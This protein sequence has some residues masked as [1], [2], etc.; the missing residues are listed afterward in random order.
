MPARDR[1]HNTVIRALA[2]AGWAVTAEQ[3]AIIVAARRLWIDFQAVN[4]AGSRV[5]LVEVKGFEYMP[6]PVDYLGEVVGKY[7]LY[8]AALEYIQVDDP[9]CL[10]VPT[11]AYEG[12]LSEDIGQQV[13]MRAGI[14]LLI[15][16]PAKEE[17]VQWLP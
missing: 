8:R 11:A 13:I 17:V 5:I 3:V 2:R 16:D 14:R 12:I 4:K 9:L 10:A 6:S 1:Y 15:F 7:V